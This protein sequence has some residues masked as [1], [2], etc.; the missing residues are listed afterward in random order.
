MPVAD[1]IKQRIQVN[2]HEST[3]CQYNPTFSPVV[4]LRRVL[5]FH[6]RYAMVD[7]NPIPTTM[8]RAWNPVM[9]KYRQK[10][11]GPPSDRARRSRSPAGKQVVIQCSW[12]SK[13]LMPRKSHAE[14]EGGE[15][16]SQ[17]LNAPP[18]SPHVPPAPW[19][20][21]SRSAPRC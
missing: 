18:T 7:T 6:T 10:K 19:S 17:G 20:G 14:D 21:W 16:K 3:K 5:P 2:P 8:C 1:Q 11:I 13:A 4:V 15:Q 9:A 12:Y